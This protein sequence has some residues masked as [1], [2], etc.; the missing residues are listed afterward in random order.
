MRGSERKSWPTAVADGEEVADGVTLS[1]VVGD[2]E[3]DGDG[4][5]DAER[6]GEADDDGDGENSPKQ[7]DGMAATL[8]NTSQHSAE[9]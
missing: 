2:A 3:S 4:E 1:P 8:P 6:D 7:L 5:V 9:K